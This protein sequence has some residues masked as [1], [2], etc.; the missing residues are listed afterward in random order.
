M[1]ECK[2]EGVYKNLRYRILR[3][4]S[5][6]Y[7]IDVDYPYLVYLFPLIFW[8]IPY[9]VYKIDD[10]N[11]LD[12]L[13]IPIKNTEKKNNVSPILAGGIS[14]FL[15]NLMRPFINN[16]NIQSSIKINACVLILILIFI[17]TLRY[18]ISRLGRRNLNR[19]VDIAI[20]KT[21]RIRI[22][23]K[24]FLTMIK[25]LFFYLLT[26]IFTLAMGCAFVEDGNLIILFI[27][28]ILLFFMLISNAFTI[29]V[30]DYKIKYIKER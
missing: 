5:N 25:I 30:S 27:F 1:I 29:I 8:I 20:L 26:A 15:A 3:E 4:G 18:Y 24:S 17:I 28:M 7:L 19:R 11:Y 21:V 16:F 12:K 22:R 13:K 23:P 9:K 10:F 6:T 2:M 14:V